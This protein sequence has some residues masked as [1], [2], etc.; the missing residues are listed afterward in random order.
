MAFILWRLPFQGVQVFDI[1]GVEVPEKHHQDRQADR[2][3]GR[4]HREDEEYEHLAGEVAEEVREGDEVQV[5]REQH[6]LDRHQQHDQVAAVEEDADHADR[7]QDRAQDQIVIHRQASRHLSVSE[8][9]ETN[10]IR[11][12][13]RTFT[14]LDGSWERLSLRLR[15]V[16]A[17]AAMIATSRTTA[18]ISK[19]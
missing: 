1:N 7:E 11:S 4:R 8:R 16:S 5:H 9:I 17:I 14:W 12:W 13:R 10:S 3:L 2:R 18:A 6:Q 19:A 15:R